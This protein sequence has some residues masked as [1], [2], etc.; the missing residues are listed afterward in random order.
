MSKKVYQFP[1]GVSNVSE[2]IESEDF[3]K[4]IE[5]NAPSKSGAEALSLMYKGVTLEL[6]TVIL[7]EN[8]AAQTVIVKYLKSVNKNK[9]NK[10]KYTF[11]LAYEGFS[12]N[13]N[14]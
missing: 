6:R 11:L 12:V 7:F 9:I 4:F 8:K 10:R 1:N 3:K 5:N 2:L 14:N 13:K